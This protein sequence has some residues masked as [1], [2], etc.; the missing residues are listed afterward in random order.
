MTRNFENWLDAYVQY[1]SF[2]EAPARL[3]YWCGVSAIAG[4][5]RRHVWI[6]QGYYQWYPNFYVILV[7]P[8]GVVA[9]STTASIAMSLLRKV[10][11]VQFGPEAVTWQALIESFENSTESFQINGAHYFQSAMTIESSE[12]GNL[13]DPSNREQIDFFVTLWDSKA[14]TFQKVT[15]GSGCNS[16]ENPY[17]NLVACTT[18]AWIA[19]NFPEYVIG[20]GFTSR[21]LFVYAEEKE[22]FVAYP[23]LHMPQEMREV[24]I[25]LV[26]DLERMATQLI[27][28]YAMDPEATKWGE[29]WYE[30]HW[31]TRIDALNDE[32]F[33]GYYSRKQTHVHKTAMCIAAATHDDLTIRKADLEA[34]VLAVNGLERDMVKVFA[35]IGRTQQSIQSERFIRFVQKRGRVSYGEAYKFIHSAFPSAKSFEDILAGAI[36][37]GFIQMVQN[38]TGGFDLVAIR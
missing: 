36:K 13:L 25:A 32:R 4:A 22:K 30:V 34:A 7:A 5:L 21:C 37:A 29:E 10:P 9:K 1:A 31:N 17:I 3:H 28:P 35:K 26:Q 16:V 33:D 2:S 38:Q 20:G 6:D 12:L 15:K 23:A 19:G 27:G 14:G 11:G 8:P 24:Q 18:P